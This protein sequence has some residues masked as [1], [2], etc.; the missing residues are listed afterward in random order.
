MRQTRDAAVRA[1]EDSMV[2]EAQER[3]PCIVIQNVSFA[4]GVTLEYPEDHS[5]LVLNC[6]F[7]STEEITFKVLPRTATQEEVDEAT[8]RLKEI[9]QD[10][11]H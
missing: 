8:A 4:A 5:L 10:L 3:G 9:Q 6:D 2:Q 1:S 7:D 11:E